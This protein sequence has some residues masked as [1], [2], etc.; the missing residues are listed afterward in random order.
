MSL[1][2]KVIHADVK[3]GTVRMRYPWARAAH[4]QH[5]PENKAHKR[6]AALKGAETELW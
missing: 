6:K 5:L 3:S 4:E 2:Q 1:G